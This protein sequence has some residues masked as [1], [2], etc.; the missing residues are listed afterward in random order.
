MG[1][2]LVFVYP[3]DTALDN[4]KSILSQLNVKITQTDEINNGLGIKVSVIYNNSPFSMV[5]YFSN[6][7]KQSTKIVF[8]NTPQE[9]Q[10]RIQS[11]IGKEVVPLTEKKQSQYI[12]ALI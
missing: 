7:T 8:E 2:S 9:L 4:L 1:N 12:L 5:L 6:K 3:K 11:R 10:E